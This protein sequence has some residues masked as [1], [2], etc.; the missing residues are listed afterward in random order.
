L[1]MMLQK[2][3]EN[4][5]FN[6]FLPFAMGPKISRLQFADDTLLCCDADATS[7]DSLRKITVCFEIVSGLHINIA[8]SELFGIHVGNEDI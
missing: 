6:G 5:L 7:V 4:G 1:N 2:G 3:N 8:K